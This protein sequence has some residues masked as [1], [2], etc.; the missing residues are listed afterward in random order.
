MSKTELCPNCSAVLQVNPGFVIWCPACNWNMDPEG[1]Q[2][3]LTLTG[4]LKR[5]LGQKSVD[6]MRSEVLEEPEMTYPRGWRTI[7]AYA[8]AGVIHLLS[9][10]CY[11]RV[12]MHF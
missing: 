9:L 7:A 5:L 10:Y 2:E 8:F 1:K 11:S 3:R 4:R 6:A 12:I